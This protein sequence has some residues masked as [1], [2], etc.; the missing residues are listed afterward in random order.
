MKVTFKVLYLWYI[1]LI[2]SPFK[3]RNKMSDFLNDFAGQYMEVIELPGETKV[4][5]AAK[6]MVASFAESAVIA[7]RVQASSD[8]GDAQ[9]LGVSTSLTQ[10]ALKFN[11]AFPDLSDDQQ[12]DIDAVV[13]GIV[14]GD[15]E[16][17]AEAW[18]NA[19]LKSISKGQAFA[20]EAKALLE[21]Q[22]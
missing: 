12:A 20:R 6:E 7:Q 4:E 21:N 11:K 18:F 16:L 19:V 9:I 13:A 14:T 10:L 17:D 2:H 3:R 15:N 1:Q 5:V 22:V 8:A